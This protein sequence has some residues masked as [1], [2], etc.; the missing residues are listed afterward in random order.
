MIMTYSDIISVDII[1]VN[2]IRKFLQYHARF[3][4][5][6]KQHDVNSLSRKS[7]AH[8]KLRS[9]FYLHAI[10]F[11]YRFLDLFCGNFP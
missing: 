8:Q 4:I 2:V 10:R 5:C 11:P 3:V 6:I 9:I 7:S 1:R